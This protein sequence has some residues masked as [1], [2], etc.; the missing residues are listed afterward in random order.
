MN[1]F[2]CKGQ[3]RPGNVNHIVDR[4]GEIIIIKNVPAIVCKQCG[5]AFYDNEVMKKVEKIVEEAKSNRAEITIINYYD[6]V[7]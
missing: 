4:D 1:C 5:E 6:K 3:M 7:A 2:M